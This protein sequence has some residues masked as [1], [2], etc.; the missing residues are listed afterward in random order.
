MKTVRSQSTK[1][2]NE[3]KG[4]KECLPCHANFVS[5]SGPTSFEPEQI[6]WEASTLPLS[7]TR[8]LIILSNLAHANVNNS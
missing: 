6:A 3:Y 8:G 5:D 1:I 4:K 7:Y 2:G